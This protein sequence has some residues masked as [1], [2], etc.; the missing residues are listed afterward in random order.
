[1]QLI[2][3]IRYAD[4]YRKRLAAGELDILI[5]AFRLYHKYI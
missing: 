1:M 4:L 5:A 2:S 3:L